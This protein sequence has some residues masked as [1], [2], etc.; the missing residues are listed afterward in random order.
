MTLATRNIVLDQH[1]KDL[2]DLISF[3]GIVMISAARG[4][5]VRIEETP[6]T[7]RNAF[8]LTAGWHLYLSIGE[9]QP[10]EIEFA[11]VVHS[12]D[13]TRHRVVHRSITQTTFVGTLNL[14]LQE[15]TQ[16]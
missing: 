13:R 16:I 10:D 5:L 1:G 9:I 7:L 8:D 6:A 15:G 11:H 3:D 14:M 2:S 4:S 12:G